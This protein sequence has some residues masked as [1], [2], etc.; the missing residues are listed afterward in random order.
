MRDVKKAE[1]E[2]DF[3][4]IGVIGFKA[5]GYHVRGSGV[6]SFMLFAGFL[7]TM[8]SVAMRLEKR[9]KLRPLRLS[10]DATAHLSGEGAG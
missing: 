6:N 9:C 1:Q 2:V 3:F 8:T 4:C 5:P 7:E 10:A